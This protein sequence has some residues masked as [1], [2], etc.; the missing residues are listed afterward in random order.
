MLHNLKLGV[1]AL[2][3]DVIK[4][5]GAVGLETGHVLHH[6]VIGPDGI[7]SDNVNVGEGTG[8]TNGLTAA[9]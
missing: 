3:D 8:Y 5:E 2:G 4:V 1:L 6:R 7:G 9:D